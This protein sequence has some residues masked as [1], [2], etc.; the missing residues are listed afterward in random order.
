[1]E[2]RKFYDPEYDRVVDETVTKK[3][4][5]WFQ[6]QSWYHDTYENFLKNNF[7]ELKEGESGEDLICGIF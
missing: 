1:M 6:S 2:G 4:Y 7:T 5:A 3:Q